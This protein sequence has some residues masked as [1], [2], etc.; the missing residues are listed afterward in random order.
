MLVNCETSGKIWFVAGPCEV[1]TPQGRKAR[2]N[3]Y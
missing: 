2:K 1:L 3:R